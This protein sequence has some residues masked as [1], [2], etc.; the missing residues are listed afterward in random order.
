MI[1]LSTKSDLVDVQ[2][3]GACVTSWQTGGIE[4][5]FLH[6]EFLANPGATTLG[7]VPV[8]FPQFGEFGSG[9]IHGTV[10]SE[11]WAPI[12]G[13]ENYQVF[14]HDAITCNG[15]KCQLSLLVRL[16]TNSLQLELK[17]ENV[18]RDTAEFTCGLHTF[19]MRDP[20]LPG[21][22]Y[23]LFCNRYLDATN[24]LQT[25]MDTDFSLAVRA[26]LD[27]VYLNVQRPVSFRQGTSKLV[28][29]DQKGFSDVVVWTP[30]VVS[31]EDEAGFVCIE[32]AQIQNPVTLQPGETWT[33][34]QTLTVR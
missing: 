4:R 10:R 12:E 32:A 15:V 7:G 25:E 5:I 28:E 23:G 13:G 14:Q 30:S 17:V 2:P 1:T 6:P 34:S 21:K 24:A 20:E 19:L 33:G 31:D 11:F 22:I 29:V 9:A 27:R 18:D 3:L 26:G 16:L 8:L